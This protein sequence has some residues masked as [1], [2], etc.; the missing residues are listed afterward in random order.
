MTVT[1]AQAASTQTA[2]IS[3][4]THLEGEIPSSTRRHLWHP[5]PWQVVRDW[6]PQRLRTLCGMVVPQAVVP[7]VPADVTAR[8]T[9]VR[10]HSPAETA[11]LALC[12]R[13]E[14][15]FAAPRAGETPPR[16]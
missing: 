7:D 1:D 12:G 2:S 4:A 3:W 5:V 15:V 10:A 9:Q 8:E 16:P 13:C 11:A 14:R 6:P